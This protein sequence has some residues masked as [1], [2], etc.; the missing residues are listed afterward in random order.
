MKTRK[1]SIA[2]KIMLFVTGAMILLLVITGVVTYSI[3]ADRLYSSAKEN[4]MNEAT[5]AANQ[6]DGD[7]FLAVVSKGEAAV[8]YQTIYDQLACFLESSTVEYIYT[9]IYADADHFQFIVDTDPEDPAD[10]GELYETEEEML[11]AWENGEP[12]VNQEPTVDEWGVVYTGYAPIKTAAGQVVGIVGVD[13]NAQ[14]VA[15]T[16]RT[17][18]VTIFIFYCIGGAVVLVGTIFFTMGIRKNFAKL[19]RAMADV[20]A[21]EGDLTKELKIHTGDELE[22]IANSFNRVLN[23]TRNIMLR[24]TDYSSEITT[25][26]QTVKNMETECT[27]HSAHV[28]SAL[29]NIVAATEEITAEIAEIRQQITI[30]NGKMEEM[31]SATGASAQEVTL[32]DE[33]AQNMK[34]TAEKAVGQI[35]SSVKDIEVRLEQENRKAKSVEEIQKLSSA[36]KAIAGQTN[37]LA[38]NASIEAAR[39]GESGR[40]FAVVAEQIGK[41]A[42]DSD[43]AAGKIQVVSQEVMEAIEGLLSVS[44]EMFEYLRNSVV[45]D[46]E[47]FSSSSIMFSEKM[48]VL[49]KNMDEL[50]NIADEYRI[51][52]ATISESVNGLGIASEENSREMTGISENMGVLNDNV[53]GIGS[54]SKQAEKAVDNMKRFLEGFR[55]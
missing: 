35:T 43:H 4:A 6:L 47:Q 38:L 39:A 14:S 51:L 52:L 31:T 10:F 17:L 55:C 34:T 36:I 54:A 30:A 19:N 41:L 5:I 28:E 1:L 29:T 16:I 46:Y 8:E 44:Q 11:L 2:A 33:N 21:D 7:A 12:S 9:M 45:A 50:Q 25:N 40:G 49:Q 20:A 24:I 42:F 18:L 32:V 13:Y 15:S 48:E 26:M 22:I 27:T 53:T 3:L 37:M 23:K